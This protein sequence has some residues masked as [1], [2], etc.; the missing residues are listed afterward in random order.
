MT[1][2][3]R[4][5]RSYQSIGELSPAAENALSQQKGWD[6]ISAPAPHAEAPIDQLQ[7]H[8]ISFWNKR[9]NSQSLA[10]TDDDS[11]ATDFFSPVN[12]GADIPPVAGYGRDGGSYQQIPTAL[13]HPAPFQ[14]ASDGT[15]SGADAASETSG[16]SGL[17]N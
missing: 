6:G 5:S 15:I 14:Q 12:T 7:A 10:T 8:D 11:Y 9:A 1:D 13:T 4:E 3:L 17:Q 16:N 2:E